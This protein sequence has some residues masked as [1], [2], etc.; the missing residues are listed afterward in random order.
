MIGVHWQNADGSS[1]PERL[2]SEA[3]LQ[4]DHP[5]SFSP[6]GKWLAYVRPAARVNAP[7]RVV[8]PGAYDP[9]VAW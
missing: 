5:T 7:L 3:A 8:S 9:P 6:D 2:T 4:Q 1:P